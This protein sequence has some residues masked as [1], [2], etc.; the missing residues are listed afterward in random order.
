MVDSVFS[1]RDLNE[2]LRFWYIDF[3]STVRTSKFKNLTMRIG[4]SRLTGID[5]E[6]KEEEEKTDNKVREKRKGGGRSKECVKRK[7]RRGRRENVVFI[8]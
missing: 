7:G 4:G 1:L 5:G 3:I 2:T 6:E 8:N